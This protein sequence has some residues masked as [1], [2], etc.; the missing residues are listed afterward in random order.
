VA[1]GSPKPR[2]SCR[3][4]SIAL[5]AAVVDAYEKATGEASPDRDDLALLMV[6]KHLPAILLRQIANPV[7]AGQRLDEGW[8]SAQRAEFVAGA[9][10]LLASVQ[11]ALTTTNEPEVALERLTEQFGDRIPSD[12]SLIVQERLPEPVQTSAVAAPALVLTD[13]ERM[14]RAEAAAR[15]T[16]AR[17]VQSRPWST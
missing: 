4:S 15:E 16:E 1:Q 8:T 11:S 5:M 14:R 13:H 6:A 3:L 10:S 12:A 9:N 17:G 2:Y 7:V